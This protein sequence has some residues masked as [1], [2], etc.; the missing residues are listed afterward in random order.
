MMNEFVDLGKRV[1]VLLPIGI[2]LVEVSEDGLLRYVELPD[3]ISAPMLSLDDAAKRYL[4]PALSGLR[5][6][7]ARSRTR[8]DA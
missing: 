2:A 1:E 4:I 6:L 7:H 8:P 3:T 5:N